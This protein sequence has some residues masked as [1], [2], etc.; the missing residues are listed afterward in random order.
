MGAAI[1]RR[2]ARRAWFVCAACLILAIASGVATT[3]AG[4]SFLLFLAPI[5]FGTGA[6]VS[7]IV[8]VV[9]ARMAVRHERL[10]SGEGVLAR[11][12]VDREQ[13]ARFRAL[14]GA[15]SLAKV[16]GI[17]WGTG[18]IAAIF[19]VAAL[20]VWFDDPGAFEL[21][22]F[23]ALLSAGFA[24]FGWLLVRDVRAFATADASP[25]AALIGHAGV[26]FRGRFVVFRAFGIRLVDARADADAHVLR[27]TYEVT[28][29]E[30]TAEHEVRVPFPPDGIDEATRVAEALRRGT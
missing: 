30:T 1:E 8:A 16:G 26:S 21:S 3:F 14:D 17:K 12:C 10:L 4:R 27:V 13:W 19:G 29:G 11:W 9:A 20:G 18:V 24:A 5:L 23:F 28:A 6:L 2:Q 15:A 22:I 7:G 25:S